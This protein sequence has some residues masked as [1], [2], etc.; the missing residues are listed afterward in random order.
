M[1]T[2]QYTV[3]QRTTKPILETTKDI[4]VEEFSISAGGKELLID[5]T[6]QITDKRRYGLVGPNGAG[7]TT[8]LKQIAGRK[9][10]IPPIDILYC[11]QEIIVDDTS[12]IQSVLNADIKRSK[13]LEDVST[14]VEG[15]KLEELYSQL[16]ET[17]EPRARKI[18]AGLGFTLEMQERSTKKFSGGWRMRISLAR[19]L[20]MEPTLLILDEP[21][22]HLDLNAVIWLNDYLQS[23]KKTLLIVSHDQSFLDDICTDIIHLENQKLYYYKG[24]YRTFR[25]MYTQKFKEQQKKYIK[26]QKE[27]KA[28]KSKG[29]PIKK[30]IEQISRP[31]EYKVKFS[32]PN[33]RELSPPIL[34][35]YDVLFAYGENVIFEHLEFGINMNS[36]VAIV[37]P[38]GVGKS[39]LLNL[40]IGKLEPQSGEVRKNH[41]L[42]I[43]VFNQHASE[44]LTHD[45]TPAS[46]LMR[47]FNIDYQFARR[48]L[49]RY[50]L[51]SHAHII[52]IE[53]LS[54]GQKAR[55]VFAELSLMEPDVLI[56]D[57]PT[58]NLDIE[59]IE[60]L[61]EA[62]ND[63]Q[64]GVIIVSHD[65]R[66][67]QDANCTLW[68][69]EDKTI[70]EIDGNFEDYR[71]EVL[72]QFEKFE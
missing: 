8:L 54:G 56:L 13:I 61:I 63:Y 48:T 50:G 22:N 72:D 18:L 2:S 69:V 21:T 62:I 38:N 28:L 36:R 51:S 32:F 59:S 19:A 71:A 60:A 9:L 26:Q 17:A 35:A 24:N 30:K 65:M 39:T 1:S 68:I 55:V 33:P 45:E 20:F 53:D 23:W 66:L 12:A 3:K 25:K 52:K 64:G 37:G 11:E 15:K 10:H 58:N 5:A 57:E 34:G 6:L 44:Q 67:I 14:C 49:G 29:V 43:G 40:L 47:K 46:Y 31:Q 42:R 70:N 41:S 16:D 4:K 27:I 7:K